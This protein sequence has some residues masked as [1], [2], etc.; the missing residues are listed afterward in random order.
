M[1]SWLHHNAKSETLEHAEARSR[2]RA[3]ASRE[4]AASYAMPSKDGMVVEE[5]SAEEF[6]RLFG[7]KQDKAA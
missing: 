2:E 7:T 4:S 6:T 5:L 1:L 3:E